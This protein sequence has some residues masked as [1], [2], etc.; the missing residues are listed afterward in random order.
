MME[1]VFGFRVVDR[2]RIMSFVGCDE[3]HHVVALTDNKQKTLN[4]VAFEMLDTDAVL[5]GMGRL[6]DAGCASVWGPGR[7]GPGNNV[8]AYFVGPFGACIEYTAEIE[9][10]DESYVPGTPES[11]AWPKGRM[12]Q[13]GIFSR[14]LEKLEASSE[15]FPY[16]AVAA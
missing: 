15:T 10:V 9:R 8:F 12:D 6:N 4:H 14:E 11:W 1:E 3:L 13:W 2:T 7:H 16:R 5:R